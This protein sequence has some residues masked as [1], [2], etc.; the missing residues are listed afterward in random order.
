[1]ESMKYVLLSTV[2][3]VYHFRMN[4]ADLDV[5]LTVNTKFGKVQGTKRYALES[6]RPVYS[7]FGIPYA[8]SPD[9]A[10]RFLPPVD[11][12]PWTGVKD[13]TNERVPFCR[14]DP[15]AVERLRANS[16]F[17]IMIEE[18]YPMQEDC[19]N[20]DIFTPVKPLRVNATGKLPVIVWFH[21]G[22]YQVTGTT[23]KLWMLPAY[24]DVVL[25]T[26]QYRLGVFG[27]LSFENK[28]APGNSGLQ[29]QTKSLEWVR[30]NIGE[31]GGNPIL[32]TIFGLSAGAFSVGAHSISPLS[33]GLFHRV[34]S[35][36]G[37]VLVPQMWDE[38]HV[39][40][41]SAIAETT[42][43][44]FWDIDHTSTCLRNRVTSSELVNAASNSNIIFKARVDGHFFPSK[45]D[46]LLENRTFD[47]NIPIMFG[48]VAGEFDFVLGR[49]VIPR[50]M[51]GS[52]MTRSN[53]EKV[54]RE[55]II[56]Y[57]P[58]IFENR[59]KVD[60]LF[61][62]YLGEN[63]SDG[64][65]LTKGVV[66]CLAD[67]LFNYNSIR[68]A[69][70][71]KDAGTDVYFYKF[72]MKPSFYYNSALGMHIPYNFNRADHSDDLPFFL[73]FPFLSEFKAKGM[74]FTSQE[75]N[76]SLKMMKML[77]TF[78]KDGVPNPDKSFDWPQYP[79]FVCINQTLTV[80]TNFRQRQMKLWET[81]LQTK[82]IELD[83]T[84]NPHHHDVD[85]NKFPFNKKEL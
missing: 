25:V 16:I 13:V 49:K 4:L 43:C 67:A 71:Y 51:R 73:G 84:N 63:S 28:C 30:D 77:A 41:S 59:Q 69:S 55:N 8:R 29:D 36:S 26:V 62:E 81:L 34:F 53:A 52:L 46:D 32:V 64:I 60:D 22:S 75:K 19:L 11:P 37:T 12:W 74:T 44:K 54:I 56:K 5:D 57:F 78:A 82:R 14:Q 79:S 1:M 23:H 15:Q 31:F 42:G 35:G 70:I 65:E 47:I 80:E 18:N 76:M 39:D 27:F 20:V 85:N 33:R 50:N 48:T 83:Q 17:G 72:D 45:V 38:S 6:N 7:Y 2:M 66:E 9:Y 24:E 58:E 68:G 40:K 21:G 3:V 61:K 10:F